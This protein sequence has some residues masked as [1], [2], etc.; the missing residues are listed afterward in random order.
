MLAINSRVS[1]FSYQSLIPGG[2]GTPRDENPESRFRAA[3]ARGGFCHAQ[4][5]PQR[6]TSPRATF[7]HPRP[8]LD[9]RLRRPLNYF[10]SAIRERSFVLEFGI[11]GPNQACRAPSEAC[12]NG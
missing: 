1:S 3:N 9:S 6:G 8:L 7:S 2:A 12:S 5:P 10:E 4:A 11:S